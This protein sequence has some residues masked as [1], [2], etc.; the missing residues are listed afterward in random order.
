MFFCI[1]IKKRNKFIFHVCHKYFFINF[2]RYN[3]NN[4]MCNVC[5]CVW[6]GITKKKKMTLKH[7]TTILN[8]LILTRN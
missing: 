2:A 8:F 3:N 6:Y 4:V 7:S 1:Q 5:G